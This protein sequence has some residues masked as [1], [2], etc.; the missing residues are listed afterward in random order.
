[1]PQDHSARPG[2]VGSSEPTTTG[3]D[4][5]PT[6]A[7][8]LPQAVDGEPTGAE[9]APQAAV[10]PSP[11]DE[12]IMYRNTE[13]EVREQP[14]L[15]PNEANPRLVP[16]PELAAEAASKGF[17]L[18]KVYYGTDR[19]PN[20]SQAE[21]WKKFHDLL[22]QTAIAGVVT[23]FL[24]AAIRVSRWRKI[25]ATLTIVALMF[26]YM[27]GRST[28]LEKN[29]IEQDDLNNNRVYGTELNEVDGKFQIERGVCFVSIPKVHEQGSGEFERPGLF[30]FKV[31]REKHFDLPEVRLIDDRDKFLSYLRA[32]VQSSPHKH[33][34]VFIH[35]YNVTFEL[36][37]MRTAQLA[38]DLGFDGPATFFSW[39]SN[40]T[41]SGYASDEETVE[42]SAPQLKEFLIDL[43]KETGAQSVDVIAHSM[44]NRAL[45]EMLID[46]ERV[47]NDDGLPVLDQVVMAA[48]DV[49][50]TKFRTKI[51][52]RIKD[53][54]RNFTLYASSKDIALLTSEILRGLDYPRLGQGGED[55]QVFP[56]IQSLQ[57]IDASDLPGEAV[58]RLEL[59][60]SYYVNPVVLKD[61]KYLVETPA[62][63]QQREWLQER[64]Y[65]PTGRYWIFDANAI[66]PVR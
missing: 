51:V 47:R 15:E 57:T 22:W 49:N 4:G 28:L 65:I 63:V 38:H 43:L 32:D 7:E 42:L 14:E 34:L 52:D 40:G 18:K 3:Q 53:A 11:P 48:P 60:H 25:F 23:L 56:D 59:G 1:M 30:E 58:F 16:S 13:P 36:A 64:P 41:T 12:I 61:L 8:E 46:L 33:A 29:R 62:P 27:S 20:I 21:R 9:E 44:G 2:E 6:G 54:A 19:K 35:G 5:E 66:S 31:D 26:T 55:R 24:L 50:S 45:T 37:A 39:P 17:L 10:A